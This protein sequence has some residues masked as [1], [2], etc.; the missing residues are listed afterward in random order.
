M[1]YYGIWLKCPWRVWVNTVQ[2]SEYV[3]SWEKAQQETVAHC[4]SYWPVYWS[5]EGD[6]NMSQALSC[7]CNIVGSILHAQVLCYMLSL[8]PSL[9]CSS[10]A[11]HYFRAVFDHV[12]LCI[13]R[14]WLWFP[15][16]MMSNMRL[17]CWRHWRRALAALL[18]CA[19]SVDC[20][21]QLSV[22]VAIGL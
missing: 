1:H 21:L 9:S 6:W 5:Q 15:V 11:L 19:V 3:I 4:V 13:W 7:A 18:V 17:L 2:Q 10:S 22:Y 20:L 14:I 16:R 12:Y 8:S